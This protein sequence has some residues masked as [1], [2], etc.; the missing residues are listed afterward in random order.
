MIV[1]F[2]GT[3]TFF[4]AVTR[5]ALPGPKTNIVRDNCVR[6]TFV[7]RRKKIVQEITRNVANV[8]SF[9]AIIAIEHVFFKA[10]TFARSLGRC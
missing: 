1:A 3:L 6:E 10:L 5:C 4:A 7:E 2:P 8:F 9:C